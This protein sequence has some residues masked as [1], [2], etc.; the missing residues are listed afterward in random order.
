M[1]EEEAMADPEYGADDEL[2]HPPGDHPTWQESVVM[3]WWDGAA[4][5]GGFHRIGH[6][7]GRGASVLWCG[8]VTRDGLRFRR[9]RTDRPLAPADR[10]GCFG[11]GPEH[12]LEVSGGRPRLRVAD[13]ELELDL[14]VDNTTPRHDLWDWS[15]HPDMGRLADRHFQVSGRARGRARIGD[16]R[17]EVDALCHRDH[18]WGPRQW[19]YVT[20]HRWI[21]G[22]FGSELS[23]AGFSFYAVDGLFMT[24]GYVCRD[25]KVTW[26][27]SVDLVLLVEPDGVTH[28]GGTATFALRDGS[29]VAIECET[30]DGVLFENHGVYCYEP[31]CIAHCDGRTGYASYEMVMNPRRGT[32]APGL[33]LRGTREEGLSRRP[34]RADAMGSQ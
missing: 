7:A 11:A 2:P 27:R 15:A 26:A 19:D 29:V 22:T 9:N 3:S 32:A 28:R 21:G 33:V 23:F 4:G 10:D 1:S 5:I 25:G 17:C 13:G 31:I 8:V 6:E 16:F 24:G 12:R 14:S 20:C 34:S 18:S 30:V